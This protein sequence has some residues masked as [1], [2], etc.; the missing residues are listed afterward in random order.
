MPAFAS[1][2]IASLLQGDAWPSSLTKESPMSRLFVILILASSCCFIACGDDDPATSTLGDA[3][4]TGTALQAEID[5]WCNYA[6]GC[7]ANLTVA[8]CQ[9]L[10]GQQFPLYRGGPLDDAIDCAIA[11][12][13]D[14]G[15][16]EACFVPDAPLPALA[17]FQSACQAK[18][19]TCAWN[20]EVCGRLNDALFSAAHIGDLQACLD[21]ADCAA[22]EACLTGL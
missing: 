2:S 15:T 18:A 20:G 7:E 13:C 16:I 11:A 5:R 22:G 14:D 4:L 1:A 9:S 12:S 6:V 17:I 10:F 21:T 3:P 8:Q 19:E